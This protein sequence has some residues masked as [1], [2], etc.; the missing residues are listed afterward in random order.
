MVLESIEG[1]MVV[2]GEQRSFFWRRREAGSELAK[3]GQLRW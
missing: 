2:R 1:A 3:F